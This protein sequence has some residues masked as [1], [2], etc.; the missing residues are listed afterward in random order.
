MSD[1]MDPKYETWLELIGS[2]TWHA[3]MH[4]L[5]LS[6]RSVHTLSPE[7]VKRVRGLAEQTCAAYVEEWAEEGRDMNRFFL[8]ELAMRV[9]EAVQSYFEFR[10]RL[11]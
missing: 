10:S 2:V 8:G 11:Q 3:A 4:G 5:H 7:H 1:D 9:Q 6:N